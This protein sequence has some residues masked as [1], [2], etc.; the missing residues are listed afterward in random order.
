VGTP[1]GLVAEDV[2]PAWLGNFT[3]TEFAVGAQS[4]VFTG[5]Q[6]IRRWPWENNPSTVFAVL[7]LP[8]QP[9]RLAA[10]S[11]VLCGRIPTEGT[12]DVF[13]PTALVFANRVLF[14]GTTRAGASALV[15]VWRPPR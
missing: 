10:A 3:T 12:S 4:I 15:S 11:P 9:G 8:V 14:H 6:S 13:N 1:E 2:T 7:D 5:G